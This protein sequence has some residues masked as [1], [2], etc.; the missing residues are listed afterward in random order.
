MA[1]SDA[2]EK[3]W[4]AEWHEPETERRESRVRE[5]ESRVEAGQSKERKVEDLPR[6]RWTVEV[7]R[8]GEREEKNS[9]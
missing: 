3:P 4:P 1:S 2:R 7:E 5:R 8:I 6:R 9:L